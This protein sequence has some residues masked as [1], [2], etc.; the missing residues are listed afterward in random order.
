MVGQGPL[1]RK[2]LPKIDWSKLGKEQT[3]IQSRGN[4]LVVAGGGPRGVLYA[5][6]RLLQVK[7]GVRWWT[8]WA[9]TIPKNRK[10]VLP[11][12]NWSETPAFEYRDPY[13]FHAF[14]SDWAAR[15]FDNG[16]NARLDRKRGGKVEYAGFVH[17][18]FGLV[19]PEK[20]FAAHPEWFSEINGVRTYRDAQLCTTN[21]EMRRELLDQVRK[22]LR[23][24]PKAKIVSVSQN[25]CFNP[26][27]CSV[28]HALSDREGDSAL[29]SR[30]G[31]LRG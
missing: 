29:V 16:F 28:C 11:S 20:W 30:S 14:D 13:W 19:P 25:D 26:C 21:P 3:L 1:A 10:L 27:R 7:C 31:Q 23:E 2:M 9:T 5:V 18:Y 17:T 12:L 8:P 22:K 4:V 24:N 6:Y 15:N